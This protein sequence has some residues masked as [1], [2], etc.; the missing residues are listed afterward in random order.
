MAG[1][2][3]R[4]IK[5]SKPFHN[6]QAEAYLNLLKTA[7]VLE[8]ALNAGMKAYGISGTQYN[9]LRI[10]RGAGPDG[11]A[12]SE[13]GSRMITHDPDITRLLDRLETRA[14]IVRQRDE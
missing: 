6:L 11:L 10:L 12:C 4:E 14:L 13:I 9:V 8:Q 1:R 2:L 3:Q 7:E 5:Q